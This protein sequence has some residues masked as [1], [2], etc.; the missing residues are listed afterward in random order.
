M[1]GYRAR[2]AQR[3]MVLISSLLLLL[4][5]TI[6]ALSMF[7]SF[8]IQEKIAGNIREKQR[9]LSAAVLAEEYAENWLDNGANSTSAA[10]DCTTLLNAN[11][12]QGQI[13]SNKLPLV[14]TDLT[15]VPWTIAGVPVG[16]SY[17]PLTM[18]VST[19]TAVS[20]SRLISPKIVESSV[21]IRVVIAFIG[22]LSMVTTKTRPRRSSLRPF[23]FSY[24][25]LPSMNAQAK[26]TMR[27]AT[28]VD[29]GSRSGA[30]A[31][32]RTLR[33]PVTGRYKV[34]RCMGSRSAAW[35]SSSI[36]SGENS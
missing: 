24:I 32:A 3:G 29:T 31:F 30:A 2:C 7:R 8:G 15:N 21:C 34:V 13:C 9:A 19:T 22:G 6:I 33:S 23:I 16:V 18:Q 17:L 27:L 36:C 14:V 10:V 28:R 5:V 12:G 35:M 4:V 26:L 11:V 1:S 20:G 25:S